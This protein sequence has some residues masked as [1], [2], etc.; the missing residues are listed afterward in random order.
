MTAIEI[1]NITKIYKSGFLQKKI[2]AVDNVN[3]EVE[4][5]A[6]FGFLGP[7]GA[8][9][10]TTIKIL[11]GLIFPSS[12]TAS[13]FGKKVPDVNIMKRVGYLPEHPSFYSHL[14]GYELLDFYARIFGLNPGERLKRIH[15]LVENVGLGKAADLRISSYSKGMVQRLGIAQALVNEPDLLI[16]DEPMEGLDPIGRKDVKDIML[17]LK[18]NG[19][20][21]FFS[22]HILP[23][24]EAV[25]DRVGMLLSGRLVSV[26]IVDELIKDSLETLVV[27][28][29][30]LSEEAVSAVGKNAM[31]IERSGTSTQFI[32]VDPN[33]CNEAV[34]LARKHGGQIV[35]IIPHAKTLEEYFMAK[36]KE[37]K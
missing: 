13:V 34:D 32:F 8:G 37:E 18:K 5:G 10:T 26:G 35:S 25:C 15:S 36:V 6:I 7:N 1:K 16:F 17:E 11:T 29:R 9:K 2:K 23:D 14:T 28:V 30:D 3:L 19:K 20:T 31:A 21:V 24:I 4:E 22:T 12:G 33:K 27:K